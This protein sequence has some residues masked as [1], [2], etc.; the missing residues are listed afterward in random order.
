MNGSVRVKASPPIEASPGV[1]QKSPSLAKVFCVCERSEQTGHVSL[2]YTFHSPKILSRSR[3]QPLPRQL[4]RNCPKTFAS[5]GDFRE[6]Q[7]T[8]DTPPLFSLAK[9][10]RL[11]AV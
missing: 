10:E 11:T 4:L 2:A 1:P 8:L 3:R 6:N 9:A 5:E 7:Q